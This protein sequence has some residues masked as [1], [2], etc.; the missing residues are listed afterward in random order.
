MNPR[1]TPRAAILS[2]IS[3]TPLM[4]TPHAATL[5]KYLTL[6]HVHTLNL[7]HKNRP[8]YEDTHRKETMKKHKHSALRLALNLVGKMCGYNIGEADC[9]NTS[10]P[11]PETVRRTPAKILI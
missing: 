7:V 4:S 1:D 6:N 10:N 5:L 8:V 2:L 9:Y 11:L 3:T